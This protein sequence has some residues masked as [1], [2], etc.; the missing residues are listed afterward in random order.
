MTAPVYFSD[1]IGRFEHWR[2]RLFSET[3]RRLGYTSHIVR[4]QGALFV[5]DTTDLIGRS[6]A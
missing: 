5:V 2:R 1:E 6:L 3:L 4:A